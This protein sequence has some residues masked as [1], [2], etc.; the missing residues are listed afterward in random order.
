MKENFLAIDDMTMKGYNRKV[1]DIWMCMKISKALEVY[2]GAK[3]NIGF[4]LLNLILSI[5]IFKTSWYEAAV[6][7]NLEHD[8]KKR[9]QHKK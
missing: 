7:I 1:E 3:T 8:L 2:I 4:L 9:W 5:N 6:K